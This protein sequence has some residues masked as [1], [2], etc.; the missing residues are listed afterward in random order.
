[1]DLDR[2]GQLLEQ[3]GIER[4]LQVGGDDADDVGALGGQASGQHIGS[5]T[6]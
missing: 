4:I 5:I 6:Q 1:M 2:L 3:F